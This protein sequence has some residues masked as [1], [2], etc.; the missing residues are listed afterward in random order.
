MESQK[1]KEKT[2]PADTKETTPCPE[3]ESGSRKRGA[4][5]GCC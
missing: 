4:S 3:C 1:E 5:G 2:S